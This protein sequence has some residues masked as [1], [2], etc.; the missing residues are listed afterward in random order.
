MRIT[1]R[2]FII[3]FAFL[4][5]KIFTGCG[6]SDIEEESPE[7]QKIKDSTQIYQA[8]ENARIHYTKALQFNEKADSKASAEEFETAVKQLYKIDAKTL[9]SQYAWN[10]DFEEISKSVVQ[11]YIVSS[12]EIPNDSKVLKL[13][14]RIGV[15]YEKIEKKSYSNSFDPQDLPKGDG[16]KLETNSSVDEYIAFFQANGRKY[17]DKWL[18]RSGKYFNLMR[19]ILK[20]NNAPEE[21]IYLSMIESGLDP[22][23]SS[24]AGAVGLWQFMPTTGTSYGLYF[25][26]NT[27]DKRDVEKSTDAA[28]KLLKDLHASFG[29]WYLAMASYNC[30]PGRITSAVQKSGSTDF[31]KLREYLPKETRNY[32]PQFIACALINLDPKKYGFKD[33][34]YGNPVE[35]DRAIIKSQVSVS[36]IAELCKTTVENI[37]DLNPQL[38]KDVTPV[39]SEGYLVKIPKGSFKE[40]AKNYEDAS[41]IEKNGFKPVYD[42]NDGTASTDNSSSYTY[43]KVDG[44]EVE[45]TKLI[46]SQS[47]RELV[48]HQLAET[49]DL[50]AVSNKYDVRP[51]DIRIWNNISYGKYPKKG[52]SLS[53]WLTAAKYKQMFGVKDKIEDKQTGEKKTEEK[54]VTDT[55]KQENKEKVEQ[56]GTKDVSQNNQSNE[57]TENNAKDVLVRKNESE[58]K[59]STKNNKEEETTEPINKKETNQKKTKTEKK[60]KGSYLT[61]T[62]KSGDNLTKI[63]DDYDIDVADIKEWNNLDSDEIYSGQKLKIYSQTKTKE[64]TTNT[65]KKNTKKTEYTVKSGDNLT[66]IADKF[67]V[68]VADIKEWNSL[69]S[70]KIV[71]GQVLEIYSDKKTTKV[72]TDKKKG[73]QK[74]YTV[75]EGD[76]LTGIADEFGVTVSEIKDWNDLESDKIYSGQVLKLYSAKETSTKKNSK[77]TKT[78]AQFHTVKKGET[79]AS[80]ANMYDMTLSELKKLN[81]LKSDEI[82][83]GQKLTVSK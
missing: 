41:D 82:I 10:K 52:D 79:L 43:Y 62:V 69:E 47:N 8:L 37:R 33:V 54:Q 2:F 58:T 35:Y 77:T 44:Y 11:D 18:Y 20:E 4:S 66:A 5:L 38:L 30:G 14:E 42:G 28:S 39:F 68:D 7:A 16:I 17:M 76:N 45:D 80:I 19:S 59:E 67:D 72:T 27:D 53:V 57:T 36:R 75:T 6:G 22:T 81:K 40:F 13:A 3:L 55:N 60:N 24:W 49:E 56:T 32:I 71:I 31:W 73:K 61:Y 83:T 48:F 15:K 21:L 26:D 34:E 50:R 12:E 9:S 29:D 70:D 65:K 64:T 23:I 63:A 25:D 46:I 1:L 51:S 74:S 78:K